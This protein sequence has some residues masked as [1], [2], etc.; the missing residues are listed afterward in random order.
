MSGYDLQRVET[1]LGNKDNQDWLGSAHGLEA[2]DS[3]TLDPASF[4]TAF[5][6]GEVPSGVEISQRADGRWGTF[7]AADVTAARRTGF[8]RS[9]VA[10]RAGVNA[11]GAVHWHGSVIAA[12]VP[13]GVGAVAPAAANHPHI[14]LV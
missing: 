11:V 7:A 2:A 1:Q 5:P 12:K 6:D 8:L 14:L 10:V 9:Q 4:L 3:A 13:L